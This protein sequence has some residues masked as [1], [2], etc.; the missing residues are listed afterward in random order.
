MTSSEIMCLRWSRSA[1]ARPLGAL[2]LMVLLYSA[3]LLADALERTP[4]AAGYTEQEARAV[5]TADEQ[6]IRELRDQEV[7]EL[8]LALSRRQPE[9]RRADLYLRLAEIH[10]EAYR[11]EFLVEGRIHDQRLEKGIAA[12]KID[13]SRSMP[14]LRLAIEACQKIIDFGIPYER[15]DQVLYFLAYNHAELGDENRSRDYYQQLVRRYSSSS[16]AVEALRELGEAAF[17]SRDYRTALPYF[18][19]VLARAA[20]SPGFQVQLPRVRHRIAWCLYRLR[21]YDKAV[22]QMKEAIRLAGMGGERLFSIREEALRDLALFMTESGNVP[23][24]IQYFRKVVGDQKFYP[25]VLESLGRQY[26]RNVEPEKAT[27]VYESLLETHPDDEAAFRVRV[28]LVDLDLRRGRYSSAL[29]RIEGIRLYSSAEGETETSWQNLRAMIRRTATE[30]HEAYRKKADRK[31]LVVAEQF[32][33]RYL[34]PILKLSDSRNETPEIRMYLADVKRE[35]GL[36]KEASALYRKVVE[37]GDKRYAKEAAA[38]WTASLA[39]AIRRDSS[40]SKKSIVVRNDPT[41]LEREFVQASDV[42][43]EALEGTTEAREARLKSSQVLAAYPGSQSEALKRIKSLMKQHPRSGQA[44]TAARLWLQI[45]ADRLTASEKIEKSGKVSRDNAEDL[46]EAIEDIREYPEVLAFDLEKG[47][48]LKA[49]LAEQQARLKVME[50]AFFE[51]DEDFKGAAK[52]YERYAAEA[53][54]PSVAGKAFENA[55]A[56]WLRINDLK[57]ADRVIGDWQKRIPDSK[58]AAQAMRNSATLLFIRGGFRGSAEVLERLA[59]FTRDP[60]PTLAGIR[61]LAGAGESEALDAMVG[62]FL[63]TFPK[64]P[65]RARALLVLA[66]EQERQET[67][68]LAIQT[69]RQCLSVAGAPEEPE[70]AVRLSRHQLQA[71]GR[72]EALGLL[73]RAV[74]FS[75]KGTGS[76][77]TAMARYELA[78]LVEQSIESPKLTRETLAKELPGRLKA[79]ERIQKAYA[80][81]LEAG[82]GF[83][84]GASRRLVQVALEL[85]AEMEQLAPGDSSVGKLVASLRATA[86][87]FFQKSEKK[88]VAAEWISAEL[89][90]MLVEVGIFQKRAVAQGPMPRLSHVEFLAFGQEEFGISKLREQLSRDTANAALWGRY[91]LW[92]AREEERPGLAAVALDRVLAIDPKSVAAL[93]NL[94]VVKIAEEPAGLDDAWVAEQVHALLK[95]ASSRETLT[96]TIRANRGQMLNYFGLHSAAKKVWEQVQLKDRSSLAEDGLGVALQGV[97][98]LSLARSAFVRS[99]EAGADSRRF[100]QAFHEAAVSA[101][102]DSAACIERLSEMRDPVGAQESFA[103]SKLKE[104]CRSWNTGKPQSN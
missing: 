94:A 101:V 79:F 78:R 26:E 29:A 47:A 16:Y 99:R 7:E 93:N 67:P 8:R 27:Q 85:A 39:D 10:I 41:D 82:G 11:F 98:N 37:G 35:R 74:R 18:E 55:V 53:R 36:S 96:T 97:G 20:Q 48:K 104:A 58:A 63:K 83:S 69:Y 15:M 65:L 21:Q 12:R 5:M 9:A 45:F 19:Q 32:Y 72:E 73:E 44:V 70:C 40:A 77:F 22:Y 49:A 1:V 103:A 42:L 80:A 24:A 31:S 68:A 89:P 81:T 50:I 102:K 2:S 86:F 13:R 46:E 91:A 30:S 51:K 100:A 71:G 57:N 4:A 75:K 62:R 60:E 87:Q 95:E 6:K 25:R 34:D 52:L 76:F 54:D 61:I 66:R 56:S 90:A 23:D 28:K 59:E 33:E 17:R 92:L 88:A 43:N 14:Y 84:I 38:L 64:S 3:P